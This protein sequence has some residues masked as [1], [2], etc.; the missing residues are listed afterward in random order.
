MSVPPIFV[1][2]HLGQ[3]FVFVQV[4]KE[5]YFPLIALPLNEVPDFLKRLE[6]HLTQR[7][8]Q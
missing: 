8:K 4:D 1:W 7:G 6:K 5:S 2:E 3:G